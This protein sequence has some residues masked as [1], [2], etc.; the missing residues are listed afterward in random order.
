MSFTLRNITAVGVF[1][2]IATGMGLFLVPSTLSTYLLGISGDDSFML[3][4]R[5]FG[6]S[7]MALGIA[8]WR[9]ERGSPGFLALLAYNVSAALYIAYV[10]LFLTNAPLLWPAVGFHFVMSIFL[11]RAWR[12]GC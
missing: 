8:C 9:S 1:A 6:I 11:I 4:C 7:L 12:I 3:I 2:E 10:G 5:F